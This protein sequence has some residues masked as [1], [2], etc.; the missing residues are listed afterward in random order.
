VLILFSVQFTELKIELTL[1]LTCGGPGQLLVWGLKHIY[2]FSDGHQIILCTGRLIQQ[3]STLLTTLLRLQWQGQKFQLPCLPFPSIPFHL[4]S[5]P[6]IILPFLRF[7]SFLCPS[8]FLSFPSLR[9]RT[10]PGDRC[11]LPE[12]DLRRSPSRNQVWC[13]LAL[14]DELWWQQI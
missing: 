9:S 7:P 1:D 11:E 13:I 2:I 14:K 12:W 4:S 8:L 10:S 3:L 5:L 6:S